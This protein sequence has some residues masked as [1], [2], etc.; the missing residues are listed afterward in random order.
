MAENIDVLD[1]LGVRTGEILPR[2]E[3]H[4]LGKIHRAVH[5][6]LFNKNNNLLLQRRSMETDHFPG[7]FSISVTGHIEAGESSSST[8]R[9]E[10]QEELGINTDDL[11]I[12]FLFSFRQ[13]AE[14]S[15][16]YIDRQIN[17]VYAAWTDFDIDRVQ[18]D[19]KEVSEVKLVS[20]SDF[21]KM[22]EDNTGELAPVYAREC[23]DVVYFLKTKFALLGD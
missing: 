5:L 23:P 16:E 7:M 15:P 11:Q 9:R 10:I 8:V 13:D 4:R 21:T 18:F 19:R 1:D 14:I 22:V 3:I 6:Y 17:D 12:D 20:F 2:K